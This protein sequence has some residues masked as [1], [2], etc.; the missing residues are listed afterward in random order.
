MITAS[1]DAGMEILAHV[2][3]ELTAHFLSKAGQNLVS[4]IVPAVL[5]FTHVRSDGFQIAST[6][7]AVRGTQVLRLRANGAFIFGKG[8]E[9]SWFPSKFTGRGGIDK[10]QQALGA[11]MTTMG[12]KYP[13]FPPILFPEGSN[14]KKDLFLNP[15]LTNVSYLPYQTLRMP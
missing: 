8:F 4:H 11:H 12:K 14:R 5:F 15:A 6:M 2:P 7:T 9:Q 13:L 10:L 3:P 1:D